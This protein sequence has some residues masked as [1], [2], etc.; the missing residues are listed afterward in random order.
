MDLRTAVF[1]VGSVAAMLNAVTSQR[2]WNTLDR[3][4]GT[5]KLVVRTR[6][7]TRRSSARKRT[8]D[9]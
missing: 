7:E 3:R 6:N 2:V 1:F 9:A 8:V 4:L 5:L